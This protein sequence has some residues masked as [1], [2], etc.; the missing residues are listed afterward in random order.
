VT[1]IATVLLAS[2]TP[3]CVND[4]VIPSPDPASTLVGLRVRL[5]IGEGGGGGGFVTLFQ[6]K[7]IK[8]I[9]AAMSPYAATMY[10][11]ILLRYEL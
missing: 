9:N 3:A 2:G 6:I 8:A 10:E 11:S 4:P 1:T 5:R 7:T